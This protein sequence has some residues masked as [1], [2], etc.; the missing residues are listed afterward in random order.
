MNTRARDVN[1]P[2]MNVGPSGLEKLEEKKKIL[3]H[4]H[5]VNHH[6]NVKVK[7]FVLLIS[8]SN[9]FCFNSQLSNK[10]IPLSTK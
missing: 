2:Y 8:W 6:K 9:G 10:V 7:M 3:W 4:M 1:V 5:C